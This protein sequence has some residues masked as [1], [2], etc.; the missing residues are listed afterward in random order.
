[1]KNQPAISTPQTNHSSASLQTKRLWLCLLVYVLVF[2]IYAAKD[3]YSEQPTVGLFNTHLPPSNSVYGNVLDPKPKRQIEDELKSRMPTS[4][5]V[6]IDRLFKG[7]TVIRHPSVVEYSVRPPKSKELLLGQQT[8][9]E[10][11]L[12]IGE[13]LGEWV[14]FRPGLG[15]ILEPNNPLDGLKSGIVLRVKE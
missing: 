9:G 4:S 14:T 8:N 10:F 13:Y 3:L 1:M 15:V 7:K 5:P 12:V 2:V 11:I 6:L